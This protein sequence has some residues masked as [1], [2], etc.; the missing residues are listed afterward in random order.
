MKSKTKKLKE[1]PPIFSE[2]EE[3]VALNYQ[4]AINLHANTKAR[5]I[6]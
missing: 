6:E 2:I 3:R 5:L 4:I 1:F